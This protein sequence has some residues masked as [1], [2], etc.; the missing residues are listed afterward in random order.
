MD[1]QTIFLPAKPRV[2]RKPRLIASSSP[3]PPPMPGPVL[4]TATFGNGYL[5]LSFDRAV[6]V[7]GVV[8]GAFVVRDAYTASVWEGTDE[9]WQDAPNLLTMTMLDQV[10]YE[11]T[12]TKLDVAAGNGIVAAPPD[13]GGSWSGE[14]N[15]EMPFP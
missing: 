2:G 15:V 12:G 11:G 3:T 14:S 6:D 5:E 10:P 13:G 9:V 7:S 8:S 4:A 1:P